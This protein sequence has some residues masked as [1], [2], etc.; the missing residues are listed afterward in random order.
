MIVPFEVPWDAEEVVDIKRRLSAT[1]WNDAVT[2]DWSQGMERGFLQ[3]LV[4]Y[5]LQDY[6]WAARRALLN[7]LPHFRA[8]IGGYG[9]H[10][11]HFKGHGTAPVPLLLMN[12]WPS[13]FVE[14]QRLA[15]LLARGDPSFEV[16]LP[17]PNRKLLRAKASAIANR[18]DPDGAPAILHHA[19]QARCGIG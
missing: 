5:W 12:G 8:E 16:L 4:R 9:V 19:A 1:R 14:Y 10:F 6:D 3:R 15:P 17:G 7:R 2:A 18:A 11:L 13:S